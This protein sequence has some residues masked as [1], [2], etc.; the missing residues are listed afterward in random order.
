MRKTHGEMWL[1]ASAAVFAFAAAVFWFLSAYETLPPM[2]AYWGRTPE[3]DPLYLAM[4]S[5]AHMNTWA[6]IFSG[7]TAICMMASLV[8]RTRKRE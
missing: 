5:A 4:E 7:L 3:S 2:V 8:V 1:D 6:S